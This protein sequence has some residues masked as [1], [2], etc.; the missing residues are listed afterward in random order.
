MKNE[1]LSD[2]QKEYLKGNFSWTPDVANMIFSH[3]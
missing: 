1:H 3:S 2:A